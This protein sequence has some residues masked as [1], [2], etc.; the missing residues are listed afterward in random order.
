[1]KHGLGAPRFAWPAK[2]LEWEKNHRRGSG[3][4]GTKDA[5]GKKDAVHNKET[6]G[7]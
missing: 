1:M 4:A 7:T 3:A 2:L 6:G 5:A